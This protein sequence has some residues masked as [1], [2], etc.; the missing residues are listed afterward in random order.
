MAR[1]VD[2]WTRFVLKG[3][4]ATMREIPVDSIT[5]V[6]LDNQ[7]VD[8]TAFQDPAHGFLPNT[9]IVK[10]KITGPLSTDGAVGMSGTG[11]AP[12]LSGSFT[13]LSAYSP[14]SIPQCA[15]PLNISLAA[16]YG[17]GAYYANGNPAFGLAAGTAT[18]G[19]WMSKFEET[20]GGKYAAEFDL[21]PG[22]TCPSWINTLPS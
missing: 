5:G 22:S 17:V 18:S 8:L 11:V 4:D 20:G 14:S 21:F 7:L 1:T 6:T 10:I 9:P 16:C 3:A 19:F 12:A 15:G 13:I 2:R